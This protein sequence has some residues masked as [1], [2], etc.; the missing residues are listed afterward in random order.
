MRSK[1][2]VSVVGSVV[3]SVRAVSQAWLGSGG[4]GDSGSG[5]AAGRTETWTC[6]DIS[7]EA[8]VLFLLGTTQTASLSLLRECKQYLYLWVCF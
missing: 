4:G 7:Q 5:I 2:G 6:V 1:P 3:G 8:T